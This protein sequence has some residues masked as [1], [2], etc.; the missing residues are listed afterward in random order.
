[1]TVW[2]NLGASYVLCLVVDT[3]CRRLDKVIGGLM[4][5]MFGSRCKLQEIRQSY[6]YVHESVAQTIHCF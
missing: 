1:M 4:C 3:I 6:L 5:I 2:N